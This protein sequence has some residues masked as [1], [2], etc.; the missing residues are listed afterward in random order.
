[1]RGSPPLTRGKG[2]DKYESAAVKGSPPL[3]RGKVLLQEAVKTTCRITPAYAGKRTSSMR[4]RYLKQDHPRLRGEKPCALSAAFSSAGSPPL[5]RGKG[6][7]AR[8]NMENHRI[9]PAY[10]GKSDQ[11]FIW[12]SKPEDHPRLRGE[13]QRALKKRLQPKGSPPLTRGKAKCR[14]AILELRRITPAYAGK[15]ELLTLLLT[16]KTDH[17]RL[18]GE[19]TFRI[20]LF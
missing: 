10:A 18:R 19:K 11:R 20:P 15:R 16:I 3:T 8:N 4:K 12:H 13:K 14:L 1:M 5:T 7:Q 2:R 6:S 9:T 17:P